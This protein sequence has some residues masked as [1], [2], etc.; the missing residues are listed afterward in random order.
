MDFWREVADRMEM[1]ARDSLE[2]RDRGWTYTLF[3][4]HSTQTSVKR[5]KALLQQSEA[6]LQWRHKYGPRSAEPNP[7]DSQLPGCEEK[8]KGRGE[9]RPLLVGEV[10]SATRL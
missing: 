1:D 10:V 9:P 5:S 2:Y 4:L 7:V 6:L 3:L 8:S